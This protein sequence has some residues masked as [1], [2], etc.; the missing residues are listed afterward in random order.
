MSE[1]IVGIESEHTG[2]GNILDFIILKNG[3]VL[4]I[5][6]EYVGLYNS[7]EDV[8]GDEDLCINGFYL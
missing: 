5:N 8:F 2:G 1:Y 3:K 4:C 6:D 7:I